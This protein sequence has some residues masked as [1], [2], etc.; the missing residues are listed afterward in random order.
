MVQKLIC[1]FTGT[2][3]IA[4]LGHAILRCLGRYKLA[5]IRGLDLSK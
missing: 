5:R 1:I 4:F 3:M 2:L